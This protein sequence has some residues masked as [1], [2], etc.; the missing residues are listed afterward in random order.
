MSGTGLSACRQHAI[1]CWV[2]LNRY[3]IPL[4][5]MLFSGPLLFP[6]SE[7]VTQAP[8]YQLSQSDVDQFHED[9]FLMIR[10]YFS[11]SEMERFS[12]IAR[13]DRE[14]LL[15]FPYTSLDA[16]G[17]P[18]K[19]FVWSKLRS[20]IYSAYARH[21]ALVEPWDQLLGGQVT[22]FHHKMMMKEPNTLG[23]WEWHQDYGYYYEHYL[24]PDMGGVMITIDEAS[25]TNGCLEVLRGSHRFG[26]VDHSRLG[27][28]SEYETAADPDRV[29]VLL[30]CCERVYCEM[31]P[32]TVLFFHANLLHHSG[33]NLS[34]SP[35]WALISNYTRTDNPP[36][37]ASPGGGENFETLSADQVQEAVKAYALRQTERDR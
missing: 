2:W 6:H 20:D 36:F 15:N 11:R 14:M 25:K 26:R 1:D 16:E 4:L 27:H 24:R 3:R 34:N 31:T 18:T 10:D 29:K 37:A 33:P 35:R 7:F 28:Q 13:C 9:G 19:L 30:A 23:A 17:R 8:N 21:E 32:G 22:Y 12:D 5:P